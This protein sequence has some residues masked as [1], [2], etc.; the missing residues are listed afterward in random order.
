MKG[1]A[2][3]EFLIVAGQPKAGSTSVF[4]WL[5]EHP[6]FR[7]SRIKEARFF[8]DADYPVPSGLRFDGANLSRYLDL[9]PEGQG[10][11]LLDASPDYMFCARA[12]EIT[13]LLP[14]ARLL[15]LR[16]DPV[17]RLISWYRYA[18]QRGFLPR[19]SSFDDFMEAQQSPATSP[20]LPV[21][22]RA[23]DQ[24][25]FDHYAEPLLEAFGARAKVID[26]DDLRR[27]P[28]DVTKDICRFVG[29]NPR[30]LDG[31]EFVTHNAS[32]GQAS[33]KISKLYYKLRADAAYRLPLSAK[34]MALLRPI[35]RFV[36]RGLS[37]KS[38]LVERPIIDDTA[39]A[40]IR[41]LASE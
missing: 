3:K 15:L 33:G 35:S 38:P 22:R 30:Y 29:A 25:R 26:F 8:L 2:D 16:R 7:P 19:G 10:R 6:E 41:R 18:A 11:I 9:F 40:Q 24:N 28:E 1:V 13:E 20:D 23:A 37:T 12:A 4:E 27:R 5:A 36:R 14:K 34:Q 31:F 39:A 32:T 17:E 21:W